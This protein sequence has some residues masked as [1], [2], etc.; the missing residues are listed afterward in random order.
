[1]KNSC[2]KLIP[3]LDHIRSSSPLNVSGGKLKDR[4]RCVF[5]SNA[6]DKKPLNS[7]NS[8]NSIALKLCGTSSMAL[9]PRA[10]TKDVHRGKSVS[11]KAKPTEDILLPN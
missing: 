9:N 5:L 8:L 11:Q 10:E 4:H 3:T 6:H 1:M 2:I 7:L